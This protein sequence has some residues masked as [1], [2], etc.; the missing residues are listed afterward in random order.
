MGSA[1]PIQKLKKRMSQ[2]KV[3]IATWVNKKLGA[4]YK[5]MMRDS[6]QASATYLRELISSEVERYL[7]KQ[8]KKGQKV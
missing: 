2:W 4:K 7:N 6:G 5:K 8:L 1:K 3:P